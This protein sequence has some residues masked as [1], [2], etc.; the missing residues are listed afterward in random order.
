[1]HFHWP[2][3]VCIFSS[4]PIC[5]PTHHT[6]ISALSRLW[7][8]VW[9]VFT[10]E[11]KWVCSWYVASAGSLGPLMMD[12]AKLPANH[13]KFWQNHA[14][15]TDRCGLQKDL[16][17]TQIVGKGPVILEVRGRQLGQF[18]KAL[19][20]CP[21]SRTKATVS[22]LWIDLG[23]HLVKDLRKCMNAE[24]KMPKPNYVSIA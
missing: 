5:P 18:Q 10:R 20:T 4:L 17:T 1:M 11:F 24:R 23:H 14:Q 13:T 7:R 22:R 16:T 9:T 12:P 19:C 8:A 2:I 21:S 6:W 3:V 15:N